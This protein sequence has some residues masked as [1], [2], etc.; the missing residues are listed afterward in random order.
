VLLYVILAR[1]QRKT[2]ARTTAFGFLLLARPIV[3]FSPKCALRPHHAPLGTGGDIALP[4]IYISYFDAP[5]QK[6]IRSGRTSSKE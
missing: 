2:S 5:C 1:L 6:P 3:V 4:A